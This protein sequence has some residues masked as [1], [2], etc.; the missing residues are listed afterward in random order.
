MNNF[1]VCLLKLPFIREWILSRVTKKYF[2]QYFD[3]LKNGTIL[4][5][6]C[7]NG[8]G[9][10]IIKKHFS[11]KKIIAFDLDPRMISQAKRYVYDRSIIFEVADAAKLPYKNNSFDAAFDYVAIHHIPSP[12][13]K[14]CLDELYRVLK[15]RGLVFIYDIAIESFNTLW[16]RVLRIITDH[17]YESMYTEEEFIS[18]L[19]K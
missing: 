11:P 5:I 13:W 10:K 6:G 7:G 2:R 18:Y 9:A 3:K 14:K 8:A 4:E 12:D 16:G 15:P 1:D 19:K 17:P